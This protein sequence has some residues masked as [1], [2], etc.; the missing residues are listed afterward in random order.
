MIRLGPSDGNCALCG[1]IE[2][3]DHSSSSARW[4][5]FSGVGSEICLGCPGTPVPD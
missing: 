2:H 3:V 1:D 5:N 4:P